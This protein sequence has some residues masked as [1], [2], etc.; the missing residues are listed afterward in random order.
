[1]E[2]LLVQSRHPVEF[3]TTL[4]DLSSDGQGRCTIAGRETQG[5][6]KAVTAHKSAKRRSLHFWHAGLPHAPQSTRLSHGPQTAKSG[7]TTAVQS[8]RA[9]AVAPDSC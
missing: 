2:T 6:L 4:G 9:Q 8:F 5:R 3:L 1:M 7:H